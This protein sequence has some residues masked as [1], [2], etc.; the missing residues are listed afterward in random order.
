MK[1]I[2]DTMPQDLSNDCV[3]HFQP[4]PQGSY[5]DENR[6]GELAHTGRESTDNG[7]WKYKRYIDTFIRG[8][9]QF[10]EDSSIDRKQCAGVIF[11][12]PGSLRG[13]PLQSCDIAEFWRSFSLRLSVR[14]YSPVVRWLLTYSRWLLQ[15]SWFYNESNLAISQWCSRQYLTQCSIS[16]PSVLTIPATNT[17]QTKL[18]CASCIFTQVLL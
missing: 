8:S 1:C 18:T 3:V 2:Y 10:S 11:G 14:L 9:I 17:R 16:L 5:G 12:T 15:T 6:L 7:V 4:Y 13:L